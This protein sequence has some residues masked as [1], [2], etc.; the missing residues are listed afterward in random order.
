ML[1]KYANLKTRLVCLLLNEIK[2][3]KD[4]Q[5]YA[6]V[7]FITANLVIV[8]YLVCFVPHE[9]DEI[10]DKYL[11]TKARSYIFKGQFLSNK[12][13]LYF[14][15]LLFVGNFTLLFC[16]GRH[17]IVQKCVSHIQHTYLSSLDQ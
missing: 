15:S 14:P 1:A 16:R 3:I 17:E 5:L 13:L 6:K 2:E 12:K 9:R 8:G 10:M 11:R 7:F 4:F